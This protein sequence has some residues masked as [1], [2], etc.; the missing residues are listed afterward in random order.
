MKLRTKNELD[1]L[2]KEYCWENNSLKDTIIFLD[3][4]QRLYNIL[5]IKEYDELA[6]ERNE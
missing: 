4:M 1:K 3:Y 6:K 5:F 2:M